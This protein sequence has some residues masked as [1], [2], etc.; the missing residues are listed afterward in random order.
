MYEKRIKE[1][2]EIALHEFLY[3]LMQGYDSVPLKADLEL[4]GNDQLF[5]LMA[6]RQI[7]K[8]YNMKPQ[9]IMTLPILVGL[10][11]KEKMSKSLG[12]YI[13]I[14]ENPRNMFGKTMSI[15]DELMG[16]W[17][18]LLTSIPLE[19]IQEILKGHPRDA[20]IRLASEI[21]KEFHSE[22]E[23][24]KAVEEFSRMFTGNKGLPDDMPEFSKEKESC[25]ALDLVIASGLCQ[26]S[27][28]ARRMFKQ[29]AV[30]IDGKKRSM[31]D[32][33]SL[34]SEVV[35]QVGKKR[36]AKCRS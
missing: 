1:G 34:K 12:N 35:V 13:G 6:G 26:S 31:D 4:G 22:E 19:E 11:G 2:K 17:F 29:N 5:N 28:D 25:T 14:D 33:I 18:E 9:A 3:P 15:P 27:S 10:D 16:S 36:F 20:K 21:V 24:K 7:Q 23:A 30:S 8:K 32:E